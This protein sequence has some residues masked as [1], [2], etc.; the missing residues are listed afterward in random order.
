MRAFLL[1]FCF[2]IVTKNNAQQ[3]CFYKHESNKSK[4]YELPIDAKVEL[5]NHYKVDKLDTFY[6]EFPIQLTQIF[7]DSLYILDVLSGKNGSV[8]WSDVHQI[9]IGTNGSDF[10]FSTATVVSS[11]V[12]LVGMAVGLSEFNFKSNPAPPSLLIGAVMLPV[13]ILFLKES[14]HHFE[15]EF[16]RITQ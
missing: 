8:K 2:F 4:C 10:L 12:S 16:Y 3:V 15:P 7:N 14:K 5:N 1:I 11:T 6:T 9:N 13:S